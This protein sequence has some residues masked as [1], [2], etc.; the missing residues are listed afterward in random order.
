MEDIFDFQDIESLKLPDRKSGVSMLLMGSTR[1]GKTTML[2]YIYEN[3]FK[4]Y[5][6]VLH[7]ASAHNDVYNKMKKSVACASQY[8]P[9]LINET[10][11]INKKTDNNYEF[12]HILDDVVDKKNDAELKKLLTIYRNTR[13]SGIITGQSLTIFNSITRGNIN[14][15]FLGYLNSD[16]AVEQAIK[17]YLTSY[18]P[19]KMR[20]ADKIKAYRELTDDYFWIVIDSI[21]NEI[22]RTKLRP[23]QLV[24]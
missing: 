10:Y 22:F 19:T 9:E 12:L 6:T 5:I 24:T 20:M 18:F 4:H 16:A 1:A 7:T 14:Y 2:N 17:S 11:R 15:V 8:H 13:I 3:V 21:H 23:D